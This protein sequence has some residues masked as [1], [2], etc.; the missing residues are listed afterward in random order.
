MPFRLSQPRSP[1]PHVRQVVSGEEADAPPRGGGRLDYDG[2][3][4]PRVVVRCASP[5][6]PHDFI[7][8]KSALFL[9]HAHTGLPVPRRQ[10]RARSFFP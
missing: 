7:V 4:E 3:M 10:S 1:S 9:S 8:A 2:S 6:L 5:V